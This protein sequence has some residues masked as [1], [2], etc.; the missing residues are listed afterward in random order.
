MNRE[1]VPAFL[2][3]LSQFEPRWVL[4]LLVAGVLS[5]QSP[6]IIKEL[7]AGLRTNQRTRRKD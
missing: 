2:N 3:F 5:W 1:S 7:F 4:V 6:R